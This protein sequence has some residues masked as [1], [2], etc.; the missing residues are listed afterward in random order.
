VNVRLCRAKYKALAP[1][2]T[3]RA[4]RIWAA[5]EA[6]AAGRGGITVVARATRIAYSTIR[7]GLQEL[8][9]RSPVEPQ[10]IR[11][12]GGGR[13][14]TLEKDPTLLTDLE[15]LVEPTASGHPM[16]PLRWTS[17]SV[18]HL[19]E[20]LQAMGHRVSRQ[21]VAELLAAAG[22]SLQANRKTREGPNHPDRDAQFRYINQ[23]VRRFQ[24]ATQPV[25]SV[26]TKKKEL[27]GDFKNAGRQ[28]RPT[29]QPAAVRVH[30]RGR[31]RPRRGWR[32]FRDR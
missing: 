1:A 27:V 26:D 14:R 17:K 10:R 3:E 6:R 4:R 23:Q 32:R 28:W 30:D 20:A 12:P 2:L 13:K 16:L 7:R 18:R 15:G 24:A 25:I 22:Y 8:E 29:G 31:R 19:A 21:L 5:T 9:A 11:R